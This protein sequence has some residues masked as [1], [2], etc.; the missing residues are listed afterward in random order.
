VAA[1]VLA[2]P[3]AHQIRTSLGV[4]G[5]ERL[6]RTATGRW[7][8]PTTANDLAPREFALRGSATH[9]AGHVVFLAWSATVTLLED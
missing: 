3:S 6:R 1:E 8:A 4:I 2:C 7:P 5:C 9:G